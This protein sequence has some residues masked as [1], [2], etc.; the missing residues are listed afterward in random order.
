[1]AVHPGTWQDLFRLAEG[2][3]LVVA[4]E[5]HECVPTRGRYS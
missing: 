2:F 3:V 1:M 4:A 5:Q